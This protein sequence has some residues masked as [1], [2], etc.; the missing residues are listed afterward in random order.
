M[1]LPALTG[2]VSPRSKS[3]SD[4]VRRTQYSLEHSTCEREGSRGLPLSRRKRALHRLVPATT[5]VLSQVFSI[6]GR[7]R[8]MFAAAAAIDLEGIVAKRKTDPYDAAVWYK[9]KNRAYTQMEGRGE[10]FHPSR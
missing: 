1:I 7:G 9:I 6:E 8:D 3:S 2:W 4:E 10:L 5:T